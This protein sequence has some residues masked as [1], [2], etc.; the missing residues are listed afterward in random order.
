LQYRVA[1]TIYHLFLAEDN[2]PELFAQAKRIHSLVPYSILKNIVRF[3]NPA[4]VMAQVLDLFM[5]QPFGTRSLLQRI[6]GMA[7]HDGINNIQK[8]IDILVSQKIQDQFLVDRIKQF[9]SA[10]AS[11]KNQIKEESEREQTDLIVAIIRSD[12]FQPEPA[13]EQIGNIFNAYV[14][15]NNAVE[16]VCFSINFDY[17]S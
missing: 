10:D 9:T 6:F 3:T 2:S 17:G 1:A 7:I 8:S 11:I 13:P 15:W 16:N 12:H 4:S 5:A 14:A